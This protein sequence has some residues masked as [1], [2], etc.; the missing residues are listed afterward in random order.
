[1]SDTIEIVLPNHAECHLRNPALRLSGEDRARLISFSGAYESEHSVFWSTE[2]RVLVLSEGWNRQWFDDIHRVLEL[3]PPPV[4]SPAMRSSLLVSD[5]LLDG[6][7]Q[8]ELRELVAGRHTIRLVMVGPTPETYALAALIRGWGHTVELDS[9]GEDAYWTSLYLDSK[10]SCLDLAREVPLMRVAPSMVVGNLVELRGALPKMLAEHGRVIV[11]TLFGVAGDG[12]AVVTGE[13]GRVERVLEDASRDSFFAFPVVIQR[14]VGHAEG[15]GCPAADLWV[16][17]DGVEDLTLCAL[18]VER[19]Y[20]FSSVDVGPGSL[21]E[22][23]GERMT[24]AAYEIG[25]AARA[26]GYYGWMCID[27]VAGVDDELYITEINARR[28]GSL[29]ANG[30]LR[31]WGA[32]KDLTVSTHFVMPVPEGTTYEDH[33]RPVFQRLWDGGVRAYPTS[34][35]ALGWPR[36]IMAVVAAASTAAEARDLVSQIR[37]S[38][39][40]AARGR[41]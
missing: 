36:P 9:V 11:R 34:L 8:K 18:T 14:F 2:P 37:D 13:P 29:H 31:H 3:A 20:K 4:V 12:T 15:V 23:W 6:A 30:L 38:I 40:A 17:E 32:E 28:S 41:G 7:A 22:V 19:G 16:G 25:E 33:I 10:M 27:A 21:P 26:L 1:M 5:L 24:R 39:E 35:R